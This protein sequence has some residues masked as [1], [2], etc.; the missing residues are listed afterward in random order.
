[1]TAD[2]DLDRL[3]RAA[4]PAAGQQAP[5]V[6]DGPLAMAAVRAGLTDGAGRPGQVVRAGQRPPARGW[7][8]VVASVVAVVAVVGLAATVSQSD[9]GG[10]GLRPG[11]AGLTT[12]PA[13]GEGQAGRGPAHRRLRP[14]LRARQAAAG[15]AAGL[16]AGRLHGAG[17]RHRPS[18]RD[19]PD[20]GPGMTMPTIGPDG[21]GMPAAYFQAVRDEGPYEG[22]QGYEYLADSIVSKGPRVG[23]LAV[24]VWRGVPDWSPDPCVVLRRIY[25][26]TGSSCQVLTA[27]GARVAV[28]E[29]DTAVG[30]A[31]P[32]A[33]RSSG[34]ATAA[35]TARSCWWRRARAC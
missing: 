11:S 21:S 1:M 22:Y 10:G 24:R 29:A 26:N 19:R 30:A 32:T 12:A 15:R 17:R 28:V 5:P 31:A 4:D 9:F 2:S 7:L 35:R 23:S 8:P 18:G 27:G 33:A 3:L 14:R 25:W 13:G 34:P 16:G 6:Q 20:L